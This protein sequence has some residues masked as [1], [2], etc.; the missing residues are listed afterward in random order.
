MRHLLPVYNF[1]N[2]LQKHSEF[3]LGVDDYVT[4]IEILRKEE[5]FPAP[6]RI[7]KIC[8]LLWL[9]PNQSE[10][11]FEKLFLHSLKYLEEELET[12]TKRLQSII[13]RENDNYSEFTSS[14]ATLESES[15]SKDD[16]DDSDEIDVMEL[17]KEIQDYSDEEDFETVDSKP[18]RNISNPSL[19]INFQKSSGE[20]LEGNSQAYKTDFQLIQNYI[21]YQ[22]RV[23]QQNWRVIQNKKKYR[24][25]EQIDIDKCINHLAKN[26]QLLNPIYYKEVENQGN[27]IVLI[28][29]R[30]SMTAFEHLAQAIAETAKSGANLEAN[31]Y[32]FRNAPKKQDLTDSESVDYIL[33]LDQIQSIYT[34]LDDILR[35]SK[36]LSIL[37]ISDAGAASKNFNYSRIEA[38]HAWL[39]KLYE[40]TLKIAWL[41]PMPIDRWDYSSSLII[42][43]LVPMYEANPQGLKMAIKI[44]QGKIKPKS[45][46]LFPKIHQNHSVI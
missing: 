3:E 29:H 27:L 9:K 1:F 15:D 5:S 37:I 34:F 21:P 10:K 24:L 13:E 11:I 41:N 35:K 40:H 17:A 44:L 6:K 28:D 36:E 30:G 16:D 33:Y 26:G 22:R 8:K 25:T 14:N 46:I 7:F 4:L 43:E 32:Y 18:Q 42:K 23:I 19:Y 12:E 45:M 31:I 38:T 39:T 2:L 20:I